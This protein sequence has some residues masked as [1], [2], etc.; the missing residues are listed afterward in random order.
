LVD[1]VSDLGEGLVFGSENIDDVQEF[2]FSD[3]AHT[4]RNQSDIARWTLLFDWWVQNADRTLGENGGNPNLLVRMSDFSV[5]IIDHNMAFDREW[6]ENVFFSDH[7]FGQMRSQSSREWLLAAKAT[8]C[9][10]MSAIDAVWK[11]LPDEWLYQDRGQTISV[12]ISMEEV[13]KVLC[14]IETELE[15]QWT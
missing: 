11:S 2:G 4:I 3:L 14:R 9:E 8:I 6:D 13:K 10:A 1:A 15:T 7:V 12:D 5:N